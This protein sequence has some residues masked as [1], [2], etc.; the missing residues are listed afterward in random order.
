MP[1]LDRV[2]QTELSPTNVDPVDDIRRYS[3]ISF[4]LAGLTSLAGVQ[5]LFTQ[6]PAPTP[7]TELAFSGTFLDPYMASIH[8]PLDGG[9]YRFQI[10]RSDGWKFPP[11][12][13]V[14]AFT[15]TPE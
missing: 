2:T 14:L 1:S 6:G 9:G 4:D 5:V 10:R 13:R 11:G 15:N 12:L 7:P 8:V 3:V